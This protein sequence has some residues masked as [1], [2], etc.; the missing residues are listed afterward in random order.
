MLIPRSSF[1]TSKLWRSDIL[2]LGTNHTPLLFWLKAA[3]PGADHIIFLFRS[4]NSYCTMSLA[5]IP[6]A[7]RPIIGVDQIPWAGKSGR[8][9]NGVVRLTPVGKNEPPSEYTVRCDSRISPLAAASARKLRS[10]RLC[11]S[12]RSRSRSR[13]GAFAAF[14]RRQRVCQSHNGTDWRWVR[15]TEVVH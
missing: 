6:S 10:G 13:C 11:S 7:D 8:S 15:R 12:G 2:I 9:I 5:I 1:L 14:P 3:L 4:K